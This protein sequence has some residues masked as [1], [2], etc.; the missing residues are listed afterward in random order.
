[1]EYSVIESAA[2]LERRLKI[3]Y[4]CTFRVCHVYIL[5]RSLLFHIDSKTSHRVHVSRVFELL[6]HFGKIFHGNKII[7]SEK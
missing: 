3:G 1:M 2:T 5:T 4:D 7:L 6:D